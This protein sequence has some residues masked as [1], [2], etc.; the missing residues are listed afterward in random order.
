MR[1][2]A[3]A[4]GC[5]T[6]ISPQLGQGAP[7]TD[8]VFCSKL[9]DKTERIACYDAAAR[10]AEARPRA[11]A[12]RE[13]IKQIVAPLP[14]AQALAKAASFVPPE[15]VRTPFQG[16]YVSGGGS[17]GITE[18]LSTGG[19]PLMRGSGFSGTAAAGYNLQYDNLVLGLELS[20]R[21]GR[22]SASASSL[23]I[24]TLNESGI[25][26]S[27][28]VWQFYSDASVHLSARAGL[29]ISDTLIFAQ[30]GV[31]AAHTKTQENFIGIGS[32]CI[33]STFVNGTFVCTATM[34]VP[35][36]V[37]RNDEWSPSFNIG[38]GIEQNFGRWFARASGQ[39]ETVLYAATDP[40]WTVRAKGEVGFRF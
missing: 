26:G 40:F 14:A 24:F 9:A 29:A 36:S 23:F 4:I 38:V 6:V 1:K 39:A 11:N 5:F 28:T 16:A 31:G 10:I 35:S 37:S 33:Q 3:F 27:R 32:I 20:G 30:A 13:P 2:V 19:S 22:E 15:V 7:S 8:L 17:Y 34:P 25:V 12:D 18:P 21:Y